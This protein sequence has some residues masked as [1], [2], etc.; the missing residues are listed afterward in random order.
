MELQV[1]DHSWKISDDEHPPLSAWLT[2]NRACN[3]RCKWCYAKMTGFD[4][5]DM[6]QK[7]ANDCISL[8]KNVGLSSVI[9]IGGEPTIHPH[10]FEIIHMIKDHEMEA[11]LVTNALR[12]ADENFLKKT[13]NAGVSSITISF[14][15]SNENDFIS[16]TGYNGF[17]QSIQAVKNIVKS[18]VNHVVNIT[19][20]QN[21]INNFDE[22]IEAVKSTGTDKFS[23]D[24]GKPI[25]LNGKSCVDGMG[26]PNEMAEFFMDIYPKLEKSGLRYSLKVAVPFCLFPQEFVEKMIADGNILTGCQ[27]IG[28]RGMIFDPQGKLLPCNHVCDLSIGKIGEDFSTA[29]EYMQF[30]KRSDVNEFYTSV[31]TC[32]QDQCIS[33][34][35]W[36]M[37]GAGCKL[38]WLHYNVED[39]MGNFPRRR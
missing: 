21:L 13:L 2:V 15:A 38:Y 37:C 33:C 35:Y 8:L 9:L 36:I 25:F 27:M 11:Y 34:P 3:L 10:F 4:S 23:I 1:D 18:G 30:R 20:C 31:S 12:F 22:M 17:K 26:T 39:M 5:N 32:P 14:K 6:T 29:N 24:T 16:D 7:T 19:A 28:N